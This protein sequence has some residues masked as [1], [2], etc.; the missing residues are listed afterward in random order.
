[1]KRNMELVRN[2]LIQIEEHNPRTVVKVIMEENDQFT[3]DEID[4]HLKLMVDAGLIDGQAKRVMGGGL[5]V[6]VRGLTWQGHDFLDA[7]R[8]DKVWE[9]AE[10]TAQDK[11]MDLSSLPLD[12]VKDL[13]VESTKALLGF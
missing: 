3:E 2:I 8:N 13:L 1:M 6:N 12:I 9:K 11:G 4:Y 10:A 5:M 7:A